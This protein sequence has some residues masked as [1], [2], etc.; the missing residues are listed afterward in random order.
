[1]SEIRRARAGARDGG[2]HICRKTD[3]LTSGFLTICKLKVVHVNEGMCVCAVQIISGL[4]NQTKFQLFT[5]F[6]VYRASR[7]GRSMLS[8]Q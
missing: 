5:L 6:S 2:W 8:R 1:M 7:H 4:D 3:N